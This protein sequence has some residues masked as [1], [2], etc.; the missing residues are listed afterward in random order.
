[1]CIAIVVHYT[2]IS[3]QSIS[4]TGLPKQSGQDWELSIDGDLETLIV[5]GYDSD[6][7]RQIFIIIPKPFIPS[8]SYDKYN[9]KSMMLS[10]WPYLIH[11]HLLL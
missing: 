6:D 11:F 7:S 9:H 8:L 3:F 5:V 10:M 1:M 2:L 4:F